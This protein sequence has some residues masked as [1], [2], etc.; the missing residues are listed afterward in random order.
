MGGLCQET[1]RWPRERYGGGS[2]QTTRIQRLV[3]PARVNP[4]NGHGFGRVVPVESIDITKLLWNKGL[5]LF[6]CSRREKQPFSPDLAATRPTQCTLQGRS[7]MSRVLLWFFFAFRRRS[8]SAGREG[9]RRLRVRCWMAGPSRSIP[10]RSRSSWCALRRRWPRW[11]PRSSPGF[12]FTPGDLLRRPV[13]EWLLPSGRSGSADSQG[14][15][16]PVDGLF[17]RVRAAA[18]HCSA[19]GGIRAGGGGSLADPAAGHSAAHRAHVG[20]R[21]AARWCSRFEL[22]NTSAG[23]VQIGALGI[24][25][26]FNNVLTN[27]SL[28]QAH[29]VC[30]FYDPYIGEDAGYLQ[31]T[32]L[33]GKG[34]ALRGHAR[35]QDAFRSL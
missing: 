13:A 22:T 21:P 33:N 17:H 34:P 12:D 29:A 15:R 26:V 35:W 27:R 10:R 7:T 5:E 31:V 20:G 2:G 30:S 14:Q 6:P 11:S 18:G 23:P 24:P 3:H 9:P 4:S 28:D 19:H 8:G 25:M 1:I 32:R 16:R